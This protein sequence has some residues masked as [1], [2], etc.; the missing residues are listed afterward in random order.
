MNNGAFKE[1]LKA[2]EQAAR[3][4]RP[5]NELRQAVLAEHP[6]IAAWLAREGLQPC[7]HVLMEPV[8]L[9]ETRRRYNEQPSAALG[10]VLFNLAF[11]C[12]KRRQAERGNVYRKGGE[13]WLNEVL[14]QPVDYCLLL[15]GFITRLRY[16]HPHPF[17][18]VPW[19]GKLV[20]PL[21]VYQGLGEFLTPECSES[22][23]VLARDRW[24][25]F[26]LEYFGGEGSHTRKPAKK[27]GLHF[28]AEKYN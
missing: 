11:D 1:R 26:C 25:D 24:D 16:V 3:A 6:L 17:G 12:V 13:D 5:V 27:L 4:A 9:P 19:A 21:L 14:R 15:A 18:L 22:G 10:E 23:G 28:S 20:N 8:N 2:L 7:P